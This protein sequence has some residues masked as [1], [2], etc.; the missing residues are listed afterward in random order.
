MPQ[1][2]GGIDD[3]NVYT[4]GLTLTLVKVVSQSCLTLTLL[5]VYSHTITLTG[6]QFVLG[7]SVLFLLLLLFLFRF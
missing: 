2:G 3:L 6:T 1:P 7:S 4:E 5:N